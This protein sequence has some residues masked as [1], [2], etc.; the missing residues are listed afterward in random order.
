[1]TTIKFTDL[2]LIVNLI[3][4]HNKLEPDTLKIPNN[5]EDTLAE[6]HSINI[7]N[8]L[9]KVLKSIDKFNLPCEF[10]L[11]TINQPIK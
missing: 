6:M 8:E 11:S 4:S 7:N 9:I 2:P 1:M 10:N 5:I 3:E